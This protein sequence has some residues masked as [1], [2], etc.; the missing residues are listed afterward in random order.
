MGAGESQARAELIRAAEA[1]NLGKRVF[2]PY[3]IFIQNTYAHTIFKEKYY[4]ILVKLNC[5]VFP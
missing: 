1:R 3:Y 5:Y 4:Q 2:L